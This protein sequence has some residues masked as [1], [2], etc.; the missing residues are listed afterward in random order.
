MNA[1]VIVVVAAIIERDGRFLVTRRL[2][3]THLAGLWEFP[4]GKVEPDETLGAS[5]ERELREEL[6]V[7]AKVGDQIVVTEH[8]Y[9]ERTVRLHFHYCE[10]QG[11]PQPLL[12]QEIRWVT[13]SELRALALPEAD[14]RLV[15]ILTEP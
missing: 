2:R 5:L 9:P 4:G 3:G 8:T 13:R 12:G 15:R 14:A 6:G 7:G 10:V 11:D 1:D